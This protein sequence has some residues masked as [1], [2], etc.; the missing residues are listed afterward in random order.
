MSTQH[1]KLQA[2]DSA[3]EL[4]VDVIDLTSEETASERLLEKLDQIDEYLRYLRN[5]TEFETIH[6][7]MYHQKRGKGHLYHLLKKHRQNKR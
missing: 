5:L 6:S 4:L 2:I 7:G 3:R 1:D